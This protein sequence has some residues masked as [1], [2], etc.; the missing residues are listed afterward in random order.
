[1]GTL[2]STHLSAAIEAG[3]ARLGPALG[4]GAA[5]L[6]AAAIAP[7]ASIGAIRA[8]TPVSPGV[9]AA[10][11]S[12]TP[13]AAPVTTPTTPIAT[14]QVDWAPVGAPPESDAL[15]ASQVTPEPENRPWNRPAND[16]VP[17]DFELRM[18]YDT[19][20]AD[21]LT[22]IQINPLYADVTGRSDLSNPSTDDLIQW[23]AHKWGI[24]EDWIR[25][26][27]VYE[28]WWRQYALG[29]LSLIPA[30]WYTAYPPEARASLGH[31]F[32]EA[33][34]TQIKWL[35]DESINPGTRRLRFLSTAFALDYMGATIRYYYD[36]DC[37]ACGQGYGPGQQWASIG[38]WH[39]PRPWNNQ[40]AQT[41]IAALQKIL[42]ARTWASPGFE[43]PCVISLSVGAC[44]HHALG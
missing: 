10:T 7:T 44:E 27:T 28:S 37:T 16:Y 41:Y 8:T 3:R 1:M 30:S 26:L 22:P 24:P 25:A 4:A 2:S 33:G 34:I 15:A 19:R 31:V 9:A 6:A 42:A 5:I 32:E 43:R 23:A 13:G 36:G 18:F 35:P 20:G 21:G 12:A 11:A 38:A 40:K 39:A 17:S 14:P 29:D